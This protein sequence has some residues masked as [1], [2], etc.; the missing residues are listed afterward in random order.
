MKIVL[1]PKLHCGISADRSSQF[2]SRLVCESSPHDEFAKTRGGKSAIQKLL[3]GRKLIA[4]IWQVWG[5]FGG[6]CAF[7]VSVIFGNA[8]Q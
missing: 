7:L 8:N 1:H 6:P 3:N 4:P 5:K 2:A